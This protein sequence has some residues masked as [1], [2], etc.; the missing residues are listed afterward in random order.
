M[1]E[2]ITILILYPAFHLQ[3]KILNMSALS[4]SSRALVLTLFFELCDN[5]VAL[6]GILKE[7]LKFFFFFFF[8]LLQRYPGLEFG[9]ILRGGGRFPILLCSGGPNTSTSTRN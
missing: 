8:F 4:S 3:L 5:W 6:H 9:E 2:R 1:L 7:V